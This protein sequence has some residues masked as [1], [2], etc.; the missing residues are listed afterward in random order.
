MLAVL[1]EAE[2]ELDHGPRITRAAPLRRCALTRA[3]LPISAMLRFV[4][5]PD[6]AV[7]PDVKKKL[8]GR[9]LWL[10][11]TREAV[12]AAQRKGVFARGFKREVRVPDTLAFDVAALLEQA[13]LDALAMAGKAG[14]IV[15]G[16]TKVEKTLAERRALA[17]I[18]ASDAAPDG[19]RKLAQIARASGDSGLNSG[20]DS[21]LGLPLVDVFSGPQLDLAL[22]RSNVVHA[23]VLAGPAGQ[24]FLARCNRLAD[25]C[26]RPGPQRAEPSA[27]TRTTQ[28]DATGSEQD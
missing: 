23:A 10:S 6:G 28:L 4:V 24:S 14:E 22:G 3:E 7:V 26:A 21:G 27:K 9:G 1:N 12:E 5:G 15:C 19:A 25:F 11:A 13:A 8:P 17:L 2:A 20:P 16:F 18:H